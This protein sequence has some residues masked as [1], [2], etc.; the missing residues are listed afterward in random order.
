MR[1]RLKNSTERKLEGGT[2]L[3]YLPITLRV[4]REDKV[5]EPTIT[6]STSEGNG[7]LDHPERGGYSSNYRIMSSQ[8]IIKDADGNTVK[9][10]VFF[11]EGR[12]INNKV[13]LALLHAGV[14]DDLTPGTYT[15]SVIA[16]LS[17]GSQHIVVEN[18]AFQKK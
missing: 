8:V 15:F 2:G 7:G 16:T 11:V 6:V 13:S 1:R 14:T 4:L 5:Y 18:V 9:D 17:D 12:E 10:K 3:A